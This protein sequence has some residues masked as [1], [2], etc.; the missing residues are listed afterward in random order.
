MASI[1]L[2]W[3]ALTIILLIQ[4]LITRTWSCCIQCRCRTLAIRT[5][6]SPSRYW[7]SYLQVYLFTYTTMANVVIGYLSCIDA[8]EAKV[9]FMV[10]SLKCTSD[11]YRA[12]LPLVYILLLAVIVAP[13][14]L[15]VVWLSRNRHRFTDE[16]FISRWGLVYEPFA[17]P[18]SYW[19]Q[20]FVLLRRAIISMTDIVLVI[21]PSYKYMIFSFLHLLS[22]LIHVIMQPY[23]TIVFNQVELVTL[24]SLTSL[25]VIL[26]AFPDARSIRNEPIIRVLVTLFV[27]VPMFGF[28]LYGLRATHRRILI[29]Y[30][31]FLRLQRSKT[32]ANFNNK[33]SNESNSISNNA[34]S[35]DLTA[36]RESP[37]FGA[38]DGSGLG[39]RRGSS[40]SNN[41]GVKNGRRN[42][43]VDDD[44]IL[45]ENLLVHSSTASMLKEFLI[46]PTGRSDSNSLMTPRTSISTPTVAQ[47]P[48]MP[49]AT[50]TR[51]GTPPSAT[52]VATPVTILGTLTPTL[53]VTP[54]SR[55]PP[56][57]A[58]NNGG[59]L[60]VPLR[61][62]A[63]TP[64]EHST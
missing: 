50:L 44:E 6:H 21:L 4:L 14:L 19:W 63:T 36:H 18:V 29:I 42:H 15:L 34:D 48:T 20:S 1:V 43:Y 46:T 53:P 61:I 30:A 52:V 23:I 38:I 2:F 56:N 57:H 22:L 35:P 32:L 60:H 17:P 3:L 55:T 10:P 25:S 39:S 41:S 47:P 26:T 40:G 51:V 9:I 45:D 13:P 37:D 49:G 24:L 7:R 64:T 54:S 16:L 5:C 59:T 11:G 27:V 62:H 8:G 31:R 33:D 28:L 58:N 12:F